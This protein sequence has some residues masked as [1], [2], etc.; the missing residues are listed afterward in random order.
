MDDD[1]E[2]DLFRVAVPA[3]G[4]ELNRDL[5]LPRCRAGRTA[6]FG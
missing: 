6:T 3:G 5:A 4:I 2:I 1:V